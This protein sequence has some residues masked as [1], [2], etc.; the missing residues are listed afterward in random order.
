MAKKQ[1][2]IVKK[3]AKHGKQSVIVVPKILQD[4]LKPG[5]IT[6]LTIEVLEENEDGKNW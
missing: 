4:H 3:I 1:F 5:M 2:V 6:Q